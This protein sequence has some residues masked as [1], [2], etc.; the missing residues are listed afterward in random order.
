[1]ITITRDIALQLLEDAVDERGADYVYPHI[2]NCTYTEN[3]K[4]SCGVGLALYSAGVPITR[5][6]ALDTKGHIP[7]VY[8]ID[9]LLRDVVDFQGDAI[10]V[11]G[12]FQSEQDYGA[13]WG[14]ALQETRNY[15]RQYA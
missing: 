13:P 8:S 12:A 11:L 2:G 1:M 6:E 7:S 10:S 3:G 5:L 9:R 4:P 14:E 15:V